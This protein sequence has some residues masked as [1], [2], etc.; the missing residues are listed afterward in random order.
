MLVLIISC[1][2]LYS[3]HCYYYFEMALQSHCRYTKY[4]QVFLHHAKEYHCISVFTVFKEQFLLKITIKLK[5][6]L[7]VLFILYSINA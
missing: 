1:S 7:N 5:I 4:K 3:V 2:Y 6:Y